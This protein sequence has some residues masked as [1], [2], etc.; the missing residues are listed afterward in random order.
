MLGIAPYLCAGADVLRGAAE[1]GH[2]EVVRYLLQKNF[3]FSKYEVQ[4]AAKKGHL[5]EQGVSVL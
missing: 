5:A 2:L 4:K 3:R 1:A